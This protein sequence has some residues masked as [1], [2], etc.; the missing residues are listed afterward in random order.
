METGAFRD[1]QGSYS[2]K[3]DLV[4]VDRRLKAITE[5]GNNTFLLK[6]R[7]FFWICSQIAV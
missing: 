5:A 6:I 4:P 7:M 2:A 3:L 1:A